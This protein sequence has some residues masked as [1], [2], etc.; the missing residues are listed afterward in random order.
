VDYLGEVPSC[1]RNSQGAFL[2]ESVA[3]KSGSVFF[4]NGSIFAWD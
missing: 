1:A 3:G 2:F 4:V